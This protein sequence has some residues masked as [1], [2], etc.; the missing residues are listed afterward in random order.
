MTGGPAWPMSV[1]SCQPAKPLNPMLSQQLHDTLA[2]AVELMETFE[3]QN[4]L[5]IHASS[6]L[7]RD[8][9][10]GN[11]ASVFNTASVAI[12]GAL[13]H[14]TTW[15][16]IVAGDL[17]RFPLPVFSHYTLA[18]AAYEPALLTLW[19][20]GPEVRRWWPPPASLGH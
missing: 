2:R 15:Y 16:Q 20:L 11:A 18:R 3:A 19:L 13:D 12:V 6:R 17:K 1:L 8:E 7:R 5:P 10:V 4:R 14:L 9:A